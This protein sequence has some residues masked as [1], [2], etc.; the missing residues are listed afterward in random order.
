MVHPVRGK[1]RS[2][3]SPS[4]PPPALPEKPPNFPFPPAPRA[5]PSS[6]TYDSGTNL[7]EVLDSSN[8]EGAILL[9]AS[10]EL[11]L[12]LPSDSRFT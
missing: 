6:F 10:N 9:D 4:P 11:V 5:S 12:A 3:S 2:T 1:R 8:A 7:I